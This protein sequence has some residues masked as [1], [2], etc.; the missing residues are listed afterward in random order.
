[1]GPH[2]PRS[3]RSRD[4]GARRSRS[5]LAGAGR[6]AHLHRRVAA[7]PAVVGSRAA[8][9]GPG[10]RAGD[11][12]AGRVRVT[13][14][15][16]HPLGRRANRHAEDEADEPVRA[17]RGV[18][19]GEF[20]GAARRRPP[21]YRR[22]DRRHARPLRQR[23]RS[24]RL[25]GHAFSG[26]CCAA[27]PARRLPGQGHRPRPAPDGPSGQAPRDRAPLADRL[28]RGHLHNSHLRDDQGRGHRR[29]VRQAG[30]DHP[31]P[32]TATCSRRCGWSTRC[33]RGGRW[34]IP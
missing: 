4:H 6:C 11:L 15:R 13:T 31:P 7:L 22:R 14:Y 23:D 32:S 24:L 21:R 9:G 26:F 33:R 19:L 17:R 28:R 20:V 34:A 27:R 3:G 25:P 12:P 1:M 8:G 5:R 16:A 10:R 29:R 2:R 18:S 30:Q